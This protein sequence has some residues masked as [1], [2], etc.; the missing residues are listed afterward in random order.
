MAVLTIKHKVDVVNNFI[1]SIESGDKS[2]YCFVAKAT[3][4]LNSNGSVDESEIITADNSVN[5]TEQ[6][7]YRDMVYGKKLSN[8][9]VTFMIKRHN[10]TSNTVYT[11]YSHTDE[12]LYDKPFYVVTET[13]QV[14]KCIHN[15]NS[16]SYPNGVPSTVKPS[17]TQTVGT[18]ETADGY[19]WKYMYT[20]DSTDYLNFQTSEYV[21]LNPNSA[22]SEA[23]VP[24]T[25]D[26]INVDNPGGGYQ[27]FEE[28]FLDGIVNNSVVKLPN[29]SSTITNYYTESSIYLK[30]GSGAGQIRKITAYDGLNG[31][32]YVN[33]SFNYYE[34]LKLANTN[35]NFDIGLLATQRT[36]TVVYFYRNGYVNEGDI[37][38]QSGTSASGKVRSAN[39][40]TIL[41]ENASN[42]DF[43]LLRPLYNTSYTHIQK[44]GLVR[45][46]AN[47]VYVNSVSSTAFT[48]DY[49]VGAYIRIGNDANTAIR[50]IT[51]VNSTVI[52]V[53][54]PF[55]NT[56]I[57]SNNYYVPSALSV[58][59]V[60]KHYT[61]GSVIYNNLNSAQIVYDTLT[62]VGKSFIIGETLVVVD[63]ANTA[64]NSNG[65]VSFS[66][67]STVILS[68]VNGS[69]NS[70][71]YLYGISSGVTAHIVS[72]DSYPNIT[73][74]T[75]YGGFI[76]GVGIYLRYANNVPTGNAIV[77][78][79]SS[80][81]N[82][83]TEYIISPTVN[84]VGD[85]NGAFAY[86]T[87]DTS[88]ENPNYGITSVNMISTGN[89]YTQANVYITS[90]TLY[91]NGAVISPQ[92]SPVHGHGYDLYSELGSTYA[93]ISIKFNNS[94]NESFK[95]PS[96]G[97]YRKVGIIKNP[98]FDDAIFE[99]GNYDRIKLTV[100]NSH[101]VFQEGE[102]VVQTSSN[103]AGVL[104]YS[105][106]TFV[107]LKN[108]KGTF[109]K[110]S[111]NT[112]N[113]STAIYGWTSG[114]NSHCTNTAISR[115][116]TSEFAPLILDTETGGSARVTQTI[117]NTMIRVSNVVG[118]FLDNDYIYE[119]YS[120]TYAN[121]TAIYVA[122]GSEDATTT[123]GLR[124]N[125]TARITLSS[126]T[127]PYELYEYVLQ[128]VTNATGRI[129]SSRDE[130]DVLQN[131]STS[132]AIGDIVVNANTGANAVVSF[133]N[134]VS[135]YMKLTSVSYGNYDEGGNPPF[136]EGDTI[137][138]E[139]NTKISTINSLYSVL[140]LDNV[141]SVV[142][143][144][145]ETYSGK[146][147]V[148]DHTIN[149]LSSEAIGTA[150]LDGSI[151]LPDLIRNTGD[152][153]YLE[154]LGKFDK[155]VSSTEQLKLIIKF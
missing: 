21:P 148:G 153:T 40:S 141:G 138:N 10:W 88:G 119:A 5:Q 50:R 94:I 97:S 74:D 56:L 98:E 154:N 135:K 78:A 111:S 77:V 140:V 113:T 110:D 60:T 75:I 31:L 105:N 39:S 17:V 93:G 11:Q 73:V 96:Y 45:V 47:S 112:G 103:A 23:V 125:Q 108:V 64:Q 122:N 32:V 92:L 41:L 52:T 95:L 58:D 35:G 120:N 115:F 54:Y 51:A 99:I 36:D 34:N 9:E 27:I 133:S 66:N 68:D 76:T 83:L 33:P 101:S 147:Q 15:G 89:Y 14:Y 84:I 20:C 142:S 19:I 146:F 57:S 121:V 37:F 106:S 30:A 150:T 132:W 85:G 6:D 81:P 102:I 131:E 1:N 28:G 86:C 100:A 128:D 13:N 22:V 44:N 130:I 117:S 107:E 67:S 139:A 144:G 26:N 38:V 104:V 29:T 24:G 69:I 114:A 118:T 143:S 55:S 72:N 149:G 126:N 59:S 7:V 79:K 129:I 70:N 12:D 2:Y 151:K 91:G 3:P 71:L 42:T 137:R 49:S 123:F 136:K 46:T 8:A 90:N 53:S 80:V 61:E 43:D 127:K 87:V 25:I 145:S 109:L 155:S 16:P 65:V 134:N 152:V 18:F 82:E 63:G 62:P 48:N 116:V 4:W 124:F